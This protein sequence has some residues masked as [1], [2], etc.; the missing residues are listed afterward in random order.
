MRK[1][2]F[3]IPYAGGFANVYRKLEP[4]LSQEISLKPLELRGRGERF[5]EG[6]YQNFQSAVDDMVNCMTKLS[7]PEDEINICGYSLGSLIAYESTLKLEKA[8]Y[9][10]KRLIVAANQAPCET[11][12][13]S[14]KQNNAGDQLTAFLKNEGETGKR[15]LNDKR[16]FNMYLSIMEAD[17]NLLYEYRKTPRFEKVNADLYVWSGVEDKEYINIDGWSKH[18]N[19][20]CLMN[21][22]PGSHFFM[23]ENPPLFAEKLNEIFAKR[24]N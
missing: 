3:C 6:L 21:S 20:K 11:V 8:G 7:K 9:N 10:V 22:F 23:L 16:F 17:F 12:D 19:G 14:E 15:I 24:K 18:T 5:Q 2:L 4:Y 1:K 13:L